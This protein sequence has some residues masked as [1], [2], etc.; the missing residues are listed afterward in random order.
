MPRLLKVLDRSFPP[1]LQWMLSA[2][3]NLRTQQK[4]ALRQQRYGVNA[5]IKET[6]Y[7][8]GNIDTLHRRS[9][10]LNE[11]KRSSSSG[12]TPLCLRIRAGSQ[13]KTIVDLLNHW[14]PAALHS[15]LSREIYINPSRCHAEVSRHLLTGRK[16]LKESSFI[17]KTASP[18][19]ITSPR[20][21]QT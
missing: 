21:W 20:F 17:W 9:V 15:R 14:L 3:P 8:Y 13:Q 6:G 12:W 1:A 18:R 11:M 2:D 5:T 4:A 16:R 19:T 7:K 10:Y